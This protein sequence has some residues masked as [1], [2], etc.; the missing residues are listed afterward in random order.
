MEAQRLFTHAGTAHLG[1]L[2]LYAALLARSQ[3]RQTPWRLRLLY[4]DP[5]SNAVTPFEEEMDCAALEAF[6]HRCCARLAKWLRELE[7]HRLRRNERLARLVFPFP[8]FRP[9]QRALSAEVYRTVR[10]G[11]A[12]LFEAPP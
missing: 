5:D 4:C 7:A 9:A 1:Q 2:R 6:L 3:V 11:G 8:S 12:L 10:D